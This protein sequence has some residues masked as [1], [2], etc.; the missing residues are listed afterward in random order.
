M[1]R[2]YP[3]R[4]N[5][6]N[7]PPSIATP[8]NDT[9]LNKMDLALYEID[10]RV[11]DFD[12]TK[13][14]QSDLL[15][16]I[17][18]LTYNT[19]TGVFTFTFWNGSTYT[20]DLNIEKIPVDFS[21][22]EYG[23]ITMTTADGTQYTCDISELVKLYTFVDSSEIDFTVT[24]DASGNKNVT[25]GIK[26]GSI[27]G[28]K[29]QPNFLADCQAASSQAQTAAGN[30]SA[31]AT[32]A[33]SSSE[34][35][36]AW[37]VGERNGVPVPS[38][39]PAYENNSKY[40]AE[41]GSN[42]FAGLTDTDFTNLQ[43][44]Q[45]AK[46]NS[47]TQKWENANESGGG[48]LLPHLYIDSEADSTVTV[49]APDS[50]VIIP[51]QISSGHWE[52][53][54]PSYGVY[55]I[56]AV[57]NG[58]DAVLSLT[59]DDVKEYHVTDSH[60]SYT[61]NVYAPTGSTIRVT[62][63]GET[64]TGTGAGSNPVQFALHQASTT[65][66]IQV[67]LDGVSK[68][69]S[70]T[71]PSTSGGTGSKTLEFGT[72]NVT[73]D[74]E[75]VGETI[76]CVNG[77]TTISKTAS[78]TS[79]VFYPPTTGTWTISGTVSGTTYSVDA[80]VVDLSTPV[81][82][83][84]ET[85]Q[86]VTV[87]LY[88]ATEDTV[89]FTDASGIQKTEVFASGQSSKSIDITIQPNGQNITFTSSVA[90]NPDDLLQYY[91]K[92][93][94]ITTSTTDIYLMPDGALYWYGYFGSVDGI[95]IEAVSNAN[96]WGTSAIGAT[97]NTNDITCTSTSGAQISGIGTKDKV[98]LANYSKITV[99]NTGV[100]SNAGT[101]AQ[102]GALDYKGANTEGFGTYTTSG[103]NK[104]EWN[105]SSWTSTYYINICNTANNRNIKIH[106]VMIE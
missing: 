1:N 32:T 40:W 92:T 33:E 8:L 75:F 77:G 66:S 16:T 18:A 12:L 22:D 100:T 46:Y 24:T 82:V 95:E 31:S 98:I 41:H 37:A 7:N 34:D 55:T 2:A 74:T 65:Y 23:V 70:V 56:H 49:V 43:N 63:T 50:S 45:I 106:A 90:K 17:K 59:V 85:L 30:A 35:S 39:D 11:V 60:Y 9:N 57:L 3:T 42:S 79:L 93:F 36:E 78:S 84:L 27:V 96:G 53:D 5:W 62:A 94:T 91:S 101:Y 99:I 44:G 86:T 10:G 68:T 51:T 6:E 72:I 61:L 69:D 71:T 52:C 67:T 58:D 15:Q 73:L 28:S 97:F 21:M 83:S 89:T 87:T 25:A 103:L 29:L 19:E 64:Y 76:T 54:V 26:E 80:E 105:I 88:S 81:S 20:V 102:A 38:T 14:N 13:A 47:T 4:I 104:K 48:G